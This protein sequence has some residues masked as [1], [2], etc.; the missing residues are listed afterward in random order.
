[1]SNGTPNIPLPQVETPTPGF[2]I[3]PLGELWFEESL[4][5][6][7]YQYF[8]GNTKKKQAEEA[9]EKLK[10]LDPDSDE[11]LKNNLEYIIN[12]AIF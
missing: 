8:T 4:P 6:S 3:R 1:M 5:A 12:L 10:Q 11:N 9:K 2:N 7:L